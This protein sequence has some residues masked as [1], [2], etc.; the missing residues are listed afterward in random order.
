MRASSRFGGEA[1]KR[2]DNAGNRQRRRQRKRCA[3]KKLIKNAPERGALVPFQVR[4]SVSVL[5]FIA[6]Q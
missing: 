1:E 2:A 5:F 6:L 3:D 4:W